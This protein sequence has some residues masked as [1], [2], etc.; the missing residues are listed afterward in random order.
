MSN[1]SSQQ[2]S[3]GSSHRTGNTSTGGGG[4]SGVDRGSS[5]HEQTEPM[6]FSSGQSFG[7]FGSVSS[8]VGKTSFD[9][10]TFGRSSSPSSE[11][12]RFRASAGWLI[13]SKYILK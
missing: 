12:G 11:L 6:D 3:G 10:S 7:A 5:K 2:T 9:G 13:F 1:S 4:G 8:A